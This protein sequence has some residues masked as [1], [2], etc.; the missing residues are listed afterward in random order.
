MAISGSSALLRVLDDAYL[1]LLFR[2]GHLMS[3]PAFQAILIVDIEGFGRRTHPVQRELRQ[4][5]Y[6]VVHTALA[7]AG[8]DP[9]RIHQED[10]GDGIV[11]IDPGTQVLRLAGPF[12]RSL[13]DALREK[14][15]MTSPEA[16]MRLRVALHQGLCEHDDSGWVGDAIN[17]TARLVDVPA[18]KDTLKAADEARMAFIVSDE[19][20]DGVI[21]HDYRSI[22]SAAFG[23]IV[24]DAKELRDE[25]AWIHVPGR[26]YPPKLPAEKP[27]PVAE[28]PVTPAPA[29]PASQSG[30]FQFNNSEVRVK[31]DM[32]AGDKIV[33]RGRR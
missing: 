17:K 18:L 30:G 27:A 32:V 1:F 3:E 21:R 6:Q 25:P 12:V 15:R 29:A 31:G 11:L 13:D 24:F 5:M 2:R 10:R 23:R 28:P 20:Y 33:K 8:L 19:I 14:A 22:D 7:D 9:G 26:S 16:T 4:A